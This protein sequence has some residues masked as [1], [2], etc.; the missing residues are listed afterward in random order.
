MSILEFKVSLLGRKDW[1]AITPE[2]FIKGASYDFKKAHE[3]EAV[4][5]YYKKGLIILAFDWELNDTDGNTH[6]IITYGK[7]EIK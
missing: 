2:S 7:V 6:L 4:L 1:S 5:E 3:Q